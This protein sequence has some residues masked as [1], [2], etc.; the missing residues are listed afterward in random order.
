[1]LR[2]FLLAA[3]GAAGTL[4]RYG[5]SVWA[6]RAARGVFPAGTMAVNLIGCFLIGALWAIFERSLV[7]P[8]QR[9]FL[10][11][12]FLGGFT[13]FSTFGL[14]T[15]SLLREG[16][17]WAAAASAAANNLIG[18]GLVMAGFFLANLFMGRAAA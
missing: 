17:Y 10:L 11:T 16:Q 14:E 3:G 8:G 5:V 9:L 1:M 18:L 7:S 6:D 2:L 12:G 15:F 4:A 13:T